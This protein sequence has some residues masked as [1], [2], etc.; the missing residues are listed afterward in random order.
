M[1]PI[2]LL[3]V[4]QFIAKNADVPRRFECKA[5]DGEATIYVYDIIGG[6]WG[7]VDAQDFAQQLAALDVETINLRVNSPGGDV[8]AARAMMLALRQHPAEIVA[9]IDGIAASAATSLVMAAD[10]V[11]MARGGRFM[12]HEAWS[13]VVGNKT[14]MSE[15]AKLLEGLDEEIV[16]D[17]V[18]RTG[19]DP[20]QLAAWMQAET[21]FNADQAK[22]AGFVDEV[23]ETTNTTD[24]RWNLAA[25]ANAPAE[26][27]EPPR[28]AA[29][30]MAAMERRVSLLLRTAA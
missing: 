27:T 15:T 3:Q 4:S 9:H 2:S 12:I 16:S 24:N 28:P 1:K 21:W 22:E 23:I 5:K 11:Q 6:A 20:K 18:G 19:A 30:D 13:I 7:G 17:Y 26:L 25:Y 10:K 29:Y 8:F 14:D